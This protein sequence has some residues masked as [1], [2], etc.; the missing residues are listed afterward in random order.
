LAAKAEEIRINTT[1]KL[2]IDNKNFFMA[3]LLSGS[4]S[5]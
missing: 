4:A 3:S 2:A 5:L 1:L